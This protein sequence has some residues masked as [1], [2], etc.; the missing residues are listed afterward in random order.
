MGGVKVLYL[1]N[2]RNALELFGWISDRC[3]AEIY[4][5]RLTVEYLSA[6]TPELVV[7]YNY[8]YIIT[9]E[10]IEYVH[11][12]I[13]NMHI[14]LLPWNRGSSPNIWSFIDDTPKGVTIHMLSGELDKGD[15]LY[16]EEAVFDLARETFETTYEKLNER[17]VALFKRNW[18]CF[19]T[20]E[21]Y[22]NAREQEGEGSYHGNAD[23]EKL[24]KELDFAW[25]DNIEI[26]LNRCNK[27]NAG[28]DFRGTSGG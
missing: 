16:Q 28:K 19:L 5:D 8:R 4:S 24:R 26:F 21:Y 14:S 20:G 7:S 10:C 13:I 6:V 2:N 23:L 15:I 12:R 25:T 18:D 17:I 22:G 1:T 11:G 9:P 3:T 27:L